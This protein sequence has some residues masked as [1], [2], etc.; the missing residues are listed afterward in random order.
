M[1]KEEVVKLEYTVRVLNK[2]IS[3]YYNKE[4]AKKIMKR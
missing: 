2:L 1:T 4:V 3:K